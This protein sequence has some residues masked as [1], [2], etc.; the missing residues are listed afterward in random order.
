M[1]IYGKILNEIKHRH[2][3]L[4]LVTKTKGIDVISEFYD[5]GHR[6]FGENKFQELKSKYEELPKDIR[7][8]FIGHLQKNK[9]KYISPFISLIHS[10]DS[11]ELISEI[12]E[13]AIKNSRIID[14]LLEIKIAAEETKHGL[15]KESC[16][17]LLENPV[18]KS[19]KS[20]R[21]CGLM[22]MAT[23]TDDIKIVS[24]EF[25]NLK[26]FFDH[27]KNQ[28][29]CDQES[30][31]ELSMGMSG[32]YQIALECGSTMVR[33]GSLILGNR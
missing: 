17:A 15:S 14:I 20:I 32:D 3:T 2:A 8:H 24:D 12:N 13:R 23:Y 11:L 4:V 18:L 5:M 10:V 26:M 33:I 27:L 31:S 19:C 6:D 30:F 25:H 1:D 29:F 22:G 21:I 16:L 28:Y 7:W 9:V